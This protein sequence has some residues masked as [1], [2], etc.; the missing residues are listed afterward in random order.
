MRHMIIWLTGLGALTG[1]GDKDENGE[2][3]ESICMVCTEYGAGTECDDERAWTASA[4][5]CDDRVAQLATIVSSDTQDT[6]AGATQDTINDA[7]GGSGDG[8]GSAGD[9]Q[10]CKIV[11]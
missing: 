8:G 3:F 10:S 4:E 6:C 7:P 9:C 1:C 11:T 2:C 5:A